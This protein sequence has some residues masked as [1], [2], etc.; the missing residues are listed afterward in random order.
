MSHRIVSWRDR[1]RYA[2]ASEHPER[3]RGLVGAWVPNLGPTGSTLFDVSGRGND[4]TL[5]NMEATDWI[6]S[7]EERSPGYLLKLGGTDESIDCG[8]GPAAIFAGATTCTLSCW[9]TRDSTSNLVVAGFGTAPFRFNILWFTDNTVYVQVENGA[10]N[11]PNFSHGGTDWWNF[12]LVYN[13]N[14][15]TAADRVVAYANGVPKA[16]TLGGDGNPASLGT[17]SELSNFFIGES[18]GG[19]R[20]STGAH[21]QVL[22]YNRALNEREVVGLYIDPMAMWRRR[23]TVGMRVPDAVGGTILPFMQHYAA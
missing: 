23:A 19:T 17:A 7:T 16:L 12:T 6:I 4:G 14:L 18:S 8:T 10:A 1:A 13:G 3:R 15:A 5:Q 22:L 9:M 21:G 20:F 2:S 11:F